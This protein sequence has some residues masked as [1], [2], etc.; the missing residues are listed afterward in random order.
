M[1]CFLRA[2]ADSVRLGTPS[3]S[4]QIP[5]GLACREKHPWWENKQ[6]DSMQAGEKV[7]L[8]Q[9]IYLVFV[10]IKL[11]FPQQPLNR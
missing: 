5:L 9:W 3:T 11:A 4:K 6:K 1:L 10:Y 7:F 8:F 2:S